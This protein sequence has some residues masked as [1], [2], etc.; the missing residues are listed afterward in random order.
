MQYWNHTSPPHSVEIE[1]RLTV[2]EQ[3]AKTHRKTTLQHGRRIT[4]LEGKKQ[5]KPQW[6]PRDFLLSAAGI[7][8]VIAALFE[9][10]GWTTALA[11]FVR[12]YGLK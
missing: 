4:A 2:V 6:T 10:I 3:D 11:G 1:H 9:K 7:T 5:Q 12:L 8:M